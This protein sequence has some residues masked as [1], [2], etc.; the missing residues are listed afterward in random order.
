MSPEIVYFGVNVK[1]QLPMYYVVQRINN[2]HLPQNQ[3]SFRKISEV[4]NSGNIGFTG[5]ITWKENP[6]TKCNPSEH[7]N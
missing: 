4:G 2:L 5:F 1:H 7:G 3:S 6:A